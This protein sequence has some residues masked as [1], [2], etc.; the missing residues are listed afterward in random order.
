MTRLRCQQFV[1]INAEVALPRLQALTDAWEVRTPVEL[2]QI[3]PI[4][5]L[6]TLTPSCHQPTFSVDQS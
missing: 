5:T 6:L 1:S 3:A 2:L 4:T